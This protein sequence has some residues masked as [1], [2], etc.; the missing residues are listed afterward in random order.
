MLHRVTVTV[1]KI[2]LRLNNYRYI[3]EPYS[4]RNTKYKCPRC[5]QNNRFVRYIDNETGQHVHPDVGR[6]DR[7]EK[8]K[9]HYTPGQYFKDN[10]RL[11]ETNLTNSPLQRFKHK[12]QPPKP[13]LEP[14]SHIPFEVFEGSLQQ[15][16]DNNFIQFL[17]SRYDQD[18]VFDVI[19]RYY[20][21]VSKHWKG[22]SVFWQIDFN[23]KIRTGKIMLYHA[24]SGKRVKQPHNH[25]NWVHSVLKLKDY[26]LKQ[27][28]FGEHLLSQF[29]QK[30]VCI[31]ESEKTAIIASLFL[32]KYNWIATGGK[33]GCRW[34]ES[35]VC[36]VL[37]NKTVILWPDLGAYEKWSTSAQSLCTLA[38]ISVSDLL[39][40]NA[41]EDERNDGLD[42]ADY[43]LNYDPG[44]FKQTEIVQADAKD[45]ADSPISSE[46]QPVQHNYQVLDKKKQA[47]NWEIDDL[48]SFFETS[49]L[50]RGPVKLND[51]ETILDVT[52][53]VNSHI[54][55]VEAHN[56]NIAY[57][58]YLERLLQLKTILN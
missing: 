40:K 10:P 36:E 1:Q 26:S 48:L 45:I 15:Y 37:K 32:P 22:A 11:S 27:C 9:Y 33:N 12:S 49:D 6:C 38:K 20:V 57:R 35:S 39:E 18:I 14:A 28:F 56:G 16:E 34:T 46:A 47:E 30:Q 54:Q 41:S 58:P 13:I 4:G 53:F 3:L 55:T 42:L 7:E 2:I 43:L 21:G 17:L 23:H 24:Q 31:V 51:W 50:P 29:P 19:N 25:I 8:C 44:D 52:K 5:G